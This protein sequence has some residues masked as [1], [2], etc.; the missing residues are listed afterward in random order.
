M[1]SDSY[2]EY[3]S[4]DYPSLLQDNGLSLHYDLSRLIPANS[5]NFVLVLPQVFD[6]FHL[7]NNFLPYPYLFLEIDR[8]TQIDT[9][10]QISSDYPW[11]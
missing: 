8:L 9:Q 4:I 7:S 2:Y 6:N 1:I 3:K 5:F 11:E 10:R